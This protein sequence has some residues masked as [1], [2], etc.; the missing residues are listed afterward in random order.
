M[1][2][3]E[4]LKYTP[5]HEWV[6]DEA[7]GELV[8]G[9]TAFAADALGDI[10]FVDLMKPGTMLA[11]GNVFG[12]VEAVKTVADLFMP[13]SGR[14]LEVNTALNESPQLINQQPYDDGWLIRV[15]PSDPDDMDGLMSALTYHMVLGN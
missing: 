2:H 4:H 6:L 8:I 13:V 15:R 9:I 11:A 12:T 5:D 3:P 1:N 14:I 7:S 10:V